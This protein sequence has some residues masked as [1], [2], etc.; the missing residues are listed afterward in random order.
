MSTNTVKSFKLKDQILELFPDKALFWREQKTL[1]VSD[2]HFGKSG[3]FRK[4]GI[5]VPESVNESNISRLDEIVQKTQ[6][7]R[8]IFLGDL[9][10][11]ESNNE[12][13]Q[14]KEWRQIYASMEMILTIGNHDL[15]TSFEYE[16]MGLNCVNQ[17]EAPPFTFLHDENDSPGS[18][19]YCISGHIHPS[20]KLKGKGR[21]Q[22]YMPCFY[23]G[24]TAALLPA[25]GS[26]TG[27]FR[28][29]PAQNESVFVIVD[30]EVIQVSVNV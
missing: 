27:N 25:F 18:D 6:P 17:F 20:I 26:F 29:S 8:L 16:K 3:H 9:F 21:Q 13:E 30:Q 14:F 28:I 12:I 23:F 2:V 1:V 22:L 19:T 11:S 4:H 15:L 7:S 10:H 24:E 5:A